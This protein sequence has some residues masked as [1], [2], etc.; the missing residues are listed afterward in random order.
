MVGDWF[1]EKVMLAGRVSGQFMSCPIFKRTVN[2]YEVL[3]ELCIYVVSTRITTEFCTTN[4]GVKLTYVV[5]PPSAKSDLFSDMNV[6]TQELTFVA[7]SP[8]FTVCTSCRG[9]VERKTIM[10]LCPLCTFSLAVNV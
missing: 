8:S 3:L 1:P 7:S 2:I 10:S 5:S 9:S 4:F 6:R